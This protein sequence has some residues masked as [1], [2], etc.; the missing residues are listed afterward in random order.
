MMPL[1]LHNS[2]ADSEKIK[3][4]AFIYCCFPENVVQIDIGML[5][6]L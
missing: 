6:M 3:S 4:Q 1:Q 2:I 5:P